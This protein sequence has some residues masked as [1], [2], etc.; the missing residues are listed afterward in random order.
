[1]SLHPPYTLLILAAIVG[2]GIW[3]TS[4]SPGELDSGLGMLLFAQMFLASS[5]F[6]VRARRGHFDPLLAGAAS[7]TGPVAWHWVVSV[8]PGVV[9]W[10]CLAGAGY[11]QGS[12]VAVSA[13]VGAR[14]AAL[15]IVSA[16]AWAAGFGL[17]RGAAGVGWIAVLF[18]LLI[19]RADL[20]SSSPAL[21]AS[22]WTGLR[23]TA[24]VVVC[25]F[26]LIGSHPA[27]APEAIGA[28]ALSSAVFLLIVLRRSGGLDIY[29]VD[30]A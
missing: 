23:H 11:F 10:I 16:L 29:L 14:A 28:A 30:R 5:G 24:T 15:F 21:A 9:G 2:I 4:M 12:P 17:T 8:A 25:P 3:T 1:L 20:L 27:L 18:G 19:G 7:R 13:L 6:V 26:L 22:G